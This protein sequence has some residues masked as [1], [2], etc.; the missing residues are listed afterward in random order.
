MQHDSLLQDSIHFYLYIPNF[1]THLSQL[2]DRSFYMFSMFSSLL[3]A[4]LVRQ[5]CR[6][7]SQLF[8]SD[9]CINM[10]LKKLC[11]FQQLTYCQH[12]KNMCVCVLSLKT[13]IN[14]YPF[15]RTASKTVHSGDRTPH[16]H[17]LKEHFCL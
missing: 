14:K 12:T 10:P 9:R 11:A 16:C 3:N 17:H 6:G 15:C 1:T 8:Q 4:S 5:I 7:G 13:R 2:R